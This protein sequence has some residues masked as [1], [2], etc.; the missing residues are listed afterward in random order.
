MS[1]RWHVY[2]DPARLAAA[3]AERISECATLAVAERDAFRIVLAGGSTPRDIY[4]ALAEH[5]AHWAKWQVYFTDER[6]LPTGHPDRND[7]MAHSTLL[8][9]A[10]IPA[11]QVHAIPAELGPERGAGAYRETLED[12]GHFDLTLLGLGEDG[13]TASLFPGHP[14]GV[15]PGA[16]DVLAVTDAPKP[17]PDRVSL[18]AARLSRASEIVVIV[19]GAGKRCAVRRLYE[20]AD[21]PI[22]SIKPT[23]SMDVVLD[24]AAAIPELMK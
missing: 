2:P 5:D 22:C 16:P 21:I 23:G 18:S 7:V 19:A 13:H 9:R 12:V 15:E 20:R 11:R 17:P 14:L 3:T 24:S 1:A 6:C 10:P 4:V 8:D